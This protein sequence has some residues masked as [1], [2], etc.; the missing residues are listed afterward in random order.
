VV[1]KSS[2]PK[3]YRSVKVVSLENRRRGKH[4][5][6]TDGIVRQLKMLKDGYALEIPLTD[7]GGVEMANLRSTVHRAATAAKLEVRTRSD[8]KN[9][10]VW[11][12]QDP[13]GE[14]DRKELA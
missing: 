3:L 2:A 4:H 10:Y 9:L 11:V 13:K 7:V 5:D 12:N 8:E 1:A 6:L 14:G